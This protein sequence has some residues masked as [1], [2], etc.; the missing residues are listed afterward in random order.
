MQQGLTGDPKAGRMALEVPHDGFSKRILPFGLRTLH[1]PT[2]PFMGRLILSFSVT[3]Q[4][5]VTTE[6][7]VAIYQ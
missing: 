6:A 7:Q 1:I 5:A 3:S 2:L 4:T